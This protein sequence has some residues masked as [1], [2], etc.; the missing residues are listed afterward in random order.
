MPSADQLEREVEEE[1]RGR[2]GHPSRGQHVLALGHSASGKTTTAKAAAAKLSMRYVYDSALLESRR[3]AD[4]TAQLFT[5]NDRTAFLPYEVEALIVRYLQNRHAESEWLCDQ[6][7]QSIWAYA[8]ARHALGELSDNE[9]QTIYA[10]FLSFA[11]ESPLPRLAVRFRCE[12]RVA[13]QRVIDRGRSHEARA[14]PVPFLIELDRAYERV[15]NALSDNVS[16]VV[17][18]T[19]HLSEAEA[20]EHLIAFINAHPAR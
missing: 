16:V 15:A 18:D 1:Y 6:G 19:T 9:L 3:F 5:L 17:L 14:L 2:L 4:Y 11:A 12:P 8:R 20:T 13:A 7:I 10:L